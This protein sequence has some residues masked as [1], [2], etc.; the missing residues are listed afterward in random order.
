VHYKT[1]PQDLWPVRIIY[2]YV[3]RV[4]GAVSIEYREF[5]EACKRTSSRSGKWTPQQFDDA[6]TRLKR[7]GM[8]NG[9]T[10]ALAESSGNELPFSFLK[11]LSAEF[12]AEIYTMYLRFRW[13]GEMGTDNPVASKVLDEWRSLLQEAS[14][15][16]ARGASKGESIA[17]LVR[18]CARGWPKSLQSW[19]LSEARKVDNS[20]KPNQNCPAEQ[21]DSPR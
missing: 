1:E 19:V 6:T 4:G 7:A 17:E 3:E 21:A 10:I 13:T 15:A 9:G 16:A 5:D 8:R 20:Q 12:S 14:P 2:A 11:L 18:E